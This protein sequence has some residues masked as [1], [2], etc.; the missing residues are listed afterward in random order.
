M[1]AV[2]AIR[3]PPDRRFH[4]QWRDT[5]TALLE[6][7]EMSLRDARGIVVRR[8]ADQ[9][10]YSAYIGCA[11]R[12]QWAKHVFVTLRDAQSWCEHALVSRT[13]N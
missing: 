9:A 8:R 7:Y 2:P 4:G 13:S 10:N 11:G 1:S 12:Q 3:A 6:R 5:S